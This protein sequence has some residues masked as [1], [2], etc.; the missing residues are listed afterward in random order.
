MSANAA[1]RITWRK[2]SHSSPQHSDC[3]EIASLGAVILVR[4]S[5]DAAGQRLAV[6]ASSWQA[7]VS[8]VKGRSHA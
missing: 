8:V 5:K 7:L 6:S 3:V 1:S 4:D 2:S